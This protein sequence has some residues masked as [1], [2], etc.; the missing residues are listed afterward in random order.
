MQSLTT[1]NLRDHWLNTPTNT[2]N[3]HQT[4]SLQGAGNWGTIITASVGWTRFLCTWAC[5]EYYCVP[6]STVSLRGPFFLGDEILKDMSTLQVEQVCSWSNSSNF[7]VM[8]H[9]L[10]GT[11]PLE[12][13]NDANISCKHCEVTFR[14]PFSI[15]ISH[16]NPLVHA[17]ICGLW[18]KLDLSHYC[19]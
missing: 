10:F 16:I 17:I 13:S 12:L 5:T 4:F 15:E 8:T 11:T 1:Q 18:M 7:S 3:T 9:G 2:L 19:V 6:T 14:E